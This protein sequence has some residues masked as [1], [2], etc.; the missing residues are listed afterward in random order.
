MLRASFFGSVCA[1]VTVHLSIHIRKPS[2]GCQ[3]NLVEFIS[4][5]PRWPIVW[6]NLAAFDLGRSSLCEP[7]PCLYIMYG[8]GVVIRGIS[9]IP[10]SVLPLH[11]PIDEVFTFP[12]SIMSNTLPCLVV[13]VCKACSREPTSTPRSICLREVEYTA[14]AVTQYNVLVSA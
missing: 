13:Q 8:C 10:L 5:E 11:F 14:P 1:I 2:C 12:Y 3:K 4:I 6:R 9:T 7:V